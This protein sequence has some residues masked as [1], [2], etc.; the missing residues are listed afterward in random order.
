M[1]H[2][3]AEYRDLK[4]TARTV[5]RYSL[6]AYGLFW[7]A[8]VT[9][10]FFVVSWE[11]RPLRLPLLIYAALEVWVIQLVVT[12]P[13]FAALWLAARL[14]F[15]RFGAPAPGVTRLFFWTSLIGSPIALAFL[16]SI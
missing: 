11:D 2:G 7:P 13:L 9:L 1:Q 8:V 15:P 3:G 4:T 10:V 6:V 12:V 5:E 16:L 14:L